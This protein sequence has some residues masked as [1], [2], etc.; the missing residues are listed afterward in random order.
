MSHEQHDTGPDDQS[1]AKVFS[2]A[3]GALIK[4]IFDAIIR[5][6]IFF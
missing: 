3:A 6:P 1:T 2:P 5:R 4:A